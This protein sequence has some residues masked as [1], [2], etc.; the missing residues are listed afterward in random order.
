MAYFNTHSIMLAFKFLHLGFIAA[1]SSWFLYILLWYWFLLLRASPPI[2]VRQGYPRLHMN[3]E[4]WI[5][6]GILIGWWSSIWENWVVNTLHNSHKQY[7]LSWCDSNQASWL[8]FKSLERPGSGGTRLV[9]RV[10]CRTARA[11]QRNPVSNP[12]PP[13]K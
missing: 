12:S 11:T 13:N 10:S 6:P 7:K 8:L 9:Y 1:F 2:A 4:P 5:P 3:L